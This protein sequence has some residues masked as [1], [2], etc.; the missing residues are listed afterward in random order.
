MDE[1]KSQSQEMNEAW[2]AVMQCERIEPKTLLL[3]FMDAGNIEQ[4]S[5]KSIRHYTLAILKRQSELDGDI[6]VDPPHKYKGWSVKDFCERFVEKLLNPDPSIK[7]ILE[8][9][10]K[11]WEEYSE[12]YDPQIDTKPVMSDL[13]TLVWAAKNPEDVAKAIPLDKVKFYYNGS[14]GHESQLKEHIDRLVKEAVKENDNIRNL[15]GGDPDMP[16]FGDE[17]SP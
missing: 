17:D 4:V 14:V 8:K 5:V 13:S 11:L 7:Q 2:D 1:L 16:S 3:I 10:T 6:F 9:K 15:L 12:D